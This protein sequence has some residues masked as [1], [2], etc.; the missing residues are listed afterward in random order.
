MNFT[1]KIKITGDIGQFVSV[2]PIEIKYVGHSIPKIFFIDEQ[3]FGNLNICELS[4]QPP[5][6]SLTAKLEYI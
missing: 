6:K 2:I 3:A 4:F 5:I 1:Q